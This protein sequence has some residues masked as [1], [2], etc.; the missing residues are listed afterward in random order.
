MLLDRAVNL[1]LVLIVV[2]IWFLMNESLNDQTKASAFDDFTG[3]PAGHCLW[4][5][6]SVP[7]FSCESCRG[8]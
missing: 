8:T 1:L 4:W 2:G 7:A 5:V 6:A 3:Q